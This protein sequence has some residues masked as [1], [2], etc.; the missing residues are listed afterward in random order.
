MSKE[1]PKYVLNKRL[2]NKKRYDEIGYKGFTINLSL[3]QFKE[4]DEYLKKNNLTREKF[5]M[6][7]I[8]KY[9]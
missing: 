2:Y 7:I 9:K 8:E 4:I 5:I 6:K 1:I 3:E